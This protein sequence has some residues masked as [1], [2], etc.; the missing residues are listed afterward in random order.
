MTDL[1]SIIIPAYNAETT[2]ENTIYSALAQTYK[3]V[4]IIIVDDRSTDKTLDTV[5]QFEGMPERVKVSQ[6][7]FRSGP[8]WSRNLGIS[9]AKGEYI[10]PLDADD[11]ITPDFIE[12]TLPLFE[13]DCYGIVS[14]DMEYFGVEQKVIPTTPRNYEHELTS[15]DIPVTSLIWRIVLDSV[16]EYK[17]GIDGWED[18]NLWL[19]ILSKGWIHGV[20]SEPLFKYRRRTNH[21]GSIAWD[22]KDE[23]ARIIRTNHP[24]FMRGRI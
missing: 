3:N 23:Y 6:T 18:W 20:V 14:T 19:D 12:K 17:L 11:L 16:S 9:R 8:A 7:D 10:L 2:I 13:K 5:M 15:N 22:R 4:E 24:E 21:F 1:V